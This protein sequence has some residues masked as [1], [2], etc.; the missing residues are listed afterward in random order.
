MYDLEAGQKRSITLPIYKELVLGD[1]LIVSTQ[2]LGEFY[3]NA[4]RVRRGRLPF[5]DPPSARRILRALAEGACYV[6]A[7][8]DYVEAAEVAERNKLSFWDALIVVA[9]SRS[10][11]ECLLT[12]DLNHGQIIEGVR[13]ENPF[14]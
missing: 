9:A 14:R 11:A 13:V 2:V 10:G 6:N 3:L 5:M 7:G 12:E 1:R 8:A 4:I